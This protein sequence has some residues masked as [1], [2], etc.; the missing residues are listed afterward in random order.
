MRRLLALARPYRRLIW[1]AVAANLLMSVFQVASIPFLQ[2]FLK[3]LFGKENTATGQM[4][5]FEAT[6]SGWY[7]R[8]LENFGRETALLAVCA[9]IVG[10]FLGK[11]LFR[12]LSLY[13]IGPARF[14]IM[15]DV[16]QRVMEKILGLPLGFFT[17][18]RKGDLMSRATGDAMEVEW[19][20]LNVVEALAREPLAIAGS[21]VFMFFI[22]PKLTLLVLVLMVVAGAAIGGLGARLRRQSGEAQSRLGALT[23]NLEEALGGLRVIK[24]F[25]AERFQ[26]HRFLI[27]NDGYR[28]ILIKIHRRKDLAAPMSEFLGIAI[29]T[30]LLVIGSRQ[31]FAGEVSAETFITFLYAFFS[32]I[33][34]AKNLSTA[35]FIIRKGLAALDRVDAL[36]A[37]PTETEMCKETG[38]LDPER[39]TYALATNAFRRS[40]EFRNVSFHYPSAER[41][42]LHDVSFEIRKGQTIALVGP[43][44]AGKSTLADLLPRFYDPTAG[45]VLLDGFDLRDLSLKNLRSMMA[46]VSQEAILF[47][48]T[49]FN[50][51]DFGSEAT[52]AEVE[53]AARVANAHEFIVKMPGGYAANI[54]DRGT[55][56]SGGQR[57]RLTIARAIL[58]N[59]PILILDEATSALDSESERLVQE[60]LSRLMSGRTTVVIAHRLS[61]VVHADEI[62]FMADGRII[63]RGSHGE[64]MGNGGAYR[65]L[66]EMQEF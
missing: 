21:L 61:T 39:S 37:L 6:M 53:A 23:A 54:G 50:N 48:D 66:V 12:Y 65:R 28:D 35:N 57:Q 9:V 41:A 15:R 49:V 34:P 29:F 19:S 59:P 27:E 10:L 42:A 47:N 31:V 8:L 55:K 17:E 63:E 18:S 1:L 32:V 13:W 40:I 30:V 26:A 64:L 4:A 14:G 36:L 46:V 16:R 33:D 62:L 20:I 7:A 5:R 2:L 22:S 11:N 38:T 58:K 43:S 25:N 45:Q 56:L 60:A 3:I 52:A 44:G 51:I 24:A